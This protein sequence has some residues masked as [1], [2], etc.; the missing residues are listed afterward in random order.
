MAVAAAEETDRSSSLLE[1]YEALLFA[2]V[3]LVVGF[4]FVFRITLVDGDSMEPTL[5][6]QDR[7]IVWAAGYTP[8]RGDVVIIDGYNPD[9]KPLVKRIIAM[10]GDT[11]DIDFAAGTVTVNGTV[12]DEPYI[13]EPTHLQGSVS[14]PLTVPEGKV[15]VMGDN[16]NGSKDSRILGCIDTRDILGKVIFRLMPFQKMGRIA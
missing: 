9:G 5:S 1:W 12:L 11:I 13:L 3:I 8:A 4:S 7:L 6:N 15:F 10:G 2:V 16:R 14:F